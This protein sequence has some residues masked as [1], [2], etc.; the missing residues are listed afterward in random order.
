MRIARSSGM[1]RPSHSFLFAS[2]LL[3]F[4]TA[5]CAATEAEPEI[6]ADEEDILPV[7]GVPPTPTSTF[8]QARTCINVLKARAGFREIDLQEGVL[9]WNCGDVNGVTVPDL[10]QEYCEFHAVLNGRIVD[11]KVAKLK[12]TDVVECLFTS[13][14]A[15]AK[16]EGEPTDAYEATLAPQIAAQLRN[17][18]KIDPAATVMQVGF[19]TRE[20]ATVL[21]DDCAGLGRREKN[22]DADRQAACAIAWTQTTDEGK[23]AALEKACKGVDLS[24]E[25]A[26]TKLKSLGVEPKA[27]DENE[28]D[29][30]AC[31]LVKSAP[32]GGVGW[33]NSDPSICARAARAARCGYDFAAIPEAFTGFELKGWTNRDALPV[34]CR[35]LEADEG[36]GRKKSSHLVVCAASRADV[37]E[38]NRARKPLQMM[39]RDKFGTNLAMQAPLRALAKKNPNA[40]SKETPAFCAAFGGDRVLGGGDG[41]GGDKGAGAGTP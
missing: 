37:D 11:R 39:C 4:T 28:R 31:A 41:S 17:A 24:K 18:T 32:N 36:E 21:V 22:L 25:A 16:G 6:G 29:V 27:D 12:S 35:Y 30:A 33:R 10:G 7:K 20:A 23:R 8:D 19:N 2:L 34:G 14:F 9:R 26:F 40:A 1:S 15:D 5:A 13:V 3:A 38:Y